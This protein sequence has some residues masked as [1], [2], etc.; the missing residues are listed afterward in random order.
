MAPELPIDIVYTWVNGSDPHLIKELKNLK[1]K[2]ANEKE[3]YVFFYLPIDH[4]LIAKF[5]AKKLRKH[6]EFVNVFT[7]TN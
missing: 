7:V 5:Q 4:F 1:Q 6:R 3:A 2:I